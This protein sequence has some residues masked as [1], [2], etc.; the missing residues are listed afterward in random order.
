LPWLL[1][2]SNASLS[3]HSNNTILDQVSMLKTFFFFLADEEAN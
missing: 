3:R 1:S 2:S